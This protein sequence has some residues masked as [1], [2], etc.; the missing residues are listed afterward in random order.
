MNKRLKLSWIDRLLNQTDGKWKNIILDKFEKVGGLDYLLACNFNANKL[1]VMFNNFW[2]D[3]LQSYLELKPINLNTREAL[4]EQIINNNAE[5][6]IGEKSFF[7]QELVDKHMYTVG[8]WFDNNGNPVSFEIVKNS[9]MLNI[10][11]L[12]YLQILSAIPKDWKILLKQRNRFHPV[13]HNTA[14]CSLKNAKI[15]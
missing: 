9:R 8:D 2:K 14:I 1:S 10:S 12:R 6:L 3:V 11:W 15:I 13:S 5:I 7:S 4:R